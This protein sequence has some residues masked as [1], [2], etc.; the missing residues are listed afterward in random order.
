MSQE[1]VNRFGDN[2]R[3]TGFWNT[4]KVAAMRVVAGEFDIDIQPIAEA[5]ETV[6]FM[7]E[8]RQGGQKTGKI[9]PVTRQVP[10]GQAYIQ[11]NFPPRNL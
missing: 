11:V 2:F 6:T 7:S 9:Y 5:G 10:E 1:K 4:D 8:E 3:I